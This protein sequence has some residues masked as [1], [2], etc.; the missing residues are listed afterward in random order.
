MVTKM[1]VK[2]Y[3]GAVK[4]VL[5]HVPERRKIARELRNNVEIYL[6]Q[7]PDAT[8]AEVYRVF[9]APEAVRAALIADMQP[10]EVDKQI[11]RAKIVRTAALVTAAVI[12]VLFVLTMAG[13]IIWNYY[14][15]PMFI[16]EE[17]FY[18]N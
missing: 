12:I 17:I 10:D 15:Q 3:I 9:G 11:K 13:I 2:A 4:K 8:M 1:E 14:S 7:N 16:T 6:E 5:W 18:L